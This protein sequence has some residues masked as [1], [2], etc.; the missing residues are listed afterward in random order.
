MIQKPLGKILVEEGYINNYQL[1]EALIKQRATPGSKLGDIL[2]E[3][4]HLAAESLNEVLKKQAEIAKRIA[5][6]NELLLKPEDQ[7]KALA[8]QNKELSALIRLLI[9][10]RL[11]NTDEYFKELKEE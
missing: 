10:K 3:L 8:I 9:K 1:S 2:I 5:S 11:I 6:K 7:E 4:G